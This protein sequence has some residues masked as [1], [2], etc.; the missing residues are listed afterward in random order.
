MKCPR[1]GMDTAA[2][3]KEWDYSAF[4][5]KRF[6]CKKCDK[7]FMVFYRDGKLSY[8]VPKVRARTLLDKIEVYIKEYVRLRS[9][10]FLYYS[11]FQIINRRIPLPSQVLQS[12]VRI[13]KDDK[14]YIRSTFSFLKRHFP[15]RARYFAKN[16]PRF[17]VGKHL[18][19]KHVKV[20]AD[21]KILEA[22]SF[23]PLQALFFR[24]EGAAVICCDLDKDLWRIDETFYHYRCN[25]C[26]DDF[27]ENVFDVVICTEVFEH[28]PC[29][30]YT[31]RNKLIGCCK[32][33]GVLLFSFPLTG[34]I[35]APYNHDFTQENDWTTEHKHLREFTETTA[36]RFLTHPE[37]KMVTRQKVYKS[38]LGGEILV[39]LCKK[40]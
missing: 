21:S 27:G 23:A 29:N 15:Q 32:N 37:L 35:F 8:T 33:Q 6:I 38:S 13:T 17:L 26:Y 5:V 34:R 31:V 20:R 30:L 3:H 1:C 9:I 40:N 10:S 19:E 11:M 39:A 14:A 12:H 36:V 18:L 7:T 22:G 16:L 28:L 24:R 25:L 2:V 4:H